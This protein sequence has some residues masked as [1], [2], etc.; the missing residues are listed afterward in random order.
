[1]THLNPS[2]L[3]LVPLIT[4]FIGW[5]TNWAAVKMIFL[6]RHFVGVGRFGWQGVVPARNEQ[7]ANDVADNVGEVISVRDL[8]DRLDPVEMEKELSGR[9]D[10]ELPALVGE[11]LE[12]LKPGVFSEMVP[13]ARAMVITQVRSEVSATAADLFDDVRQISDE[14]LD[15]K[16]LVKD[17]LSGENADRL[18]ELFARMGR[19]ELRFIVYYGG[20][21]GLLIGI[22]QALLFGVLGQWWVIPIVGA[23]VGLGT[24][25][26]ALKMIFRPLEPRRYLGFIPYQG[27]FPK[28]QPEIAREY[29]EVAA[30]EIF[31]PANLL[32]VLLEGEAGARIAVVVTMRVTEAIDANLAAVS[33]LTSTEVSMAR[34]REV[35]LLLVERVGGQLPQLRREIEEIVAKRLAVAELVET[36]IAE[37]PKVDFE[38]L[39]R[40]IFEEDE[41]ILIVIG[42]VLGGLVGLLQAAIVLAM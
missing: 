40:G 19:K 29:G 26:L 13:A 1:M 2:V 35:Q 34:V 22:V 8:A 25:W 5:V 31:T 12:L 30:E 21:F 20:I 23:I 15:L 32:R 24:N 18:G 11:V 4:A 10:E 7:F 9:L 14:S 41:W 36:R 28:R 27:M 6:P 3:I 42:G 33:M 17:L 37:M 38:R 39:L 16:A